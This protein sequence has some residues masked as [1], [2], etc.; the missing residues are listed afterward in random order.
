VQRCIDFNCD[1][2]EGYDD[3]ALMPY[4]SAANIA[5][6]LHAGD[7][8]TMRRTIGLCLQHGVAMGAHPSFD[9]RD[10][11]GRREVFCTTDEI[12]SLLRRQIGALA[13]IAGSQGAPLSH[14][15]PHGALYNMAAR[16]RALADAIA[17][18]VHEFDPELILYGLS[19]SA[20]TDAGERMGL[21]VAHE[22]FAERRYEADGRLVA[23]GQPDAVIHDLG[24]SLAQVRSIV[25][26]GRVIS[27]SGE[28]V[29]LRADTLCLHGD[30]ADATE[31]ACA[32]RAALQA[33]GIEV[34]APNAKHRV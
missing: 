5:C 20:L 22:V 10:G 3:A 11:F 28:W 23:R 27:R 15:K 24:V 16:D 7:V 18:T 33:D 25:R 9:D 29:S 26:D 6:G 19:G 1:L 34:A 8:E 2:G 14:V 4:I 30:R 17:G 12:R 21:R 32:V 31:F 13:D